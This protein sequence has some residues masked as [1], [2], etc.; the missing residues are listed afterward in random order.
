M[1]I[2]I[3]EDEPKITQHLEH[4]IHQ[5]PFPV[6]IQAKLTTV[7]AAIR[8]LEC[9]PAPDLILADVMLKDGI[10]LEIFDY[11]QLPT[12]VIYC[13]NYQNYALDA[14]NSHVIDYILKPIT[15][16]KLISSLE[17]FAKRTNY[18]GPSSS[19]PKQIDYITVSKSTK[20]LTIP[21]VSIRYIYLKEELVILQTLKNTYQLSQT[22]DE[23]EHLLNPITFYRANRQFI[24]HRQTI[25]SIEYLAARKI[26]IWLNPCIGSPVVVSKAKSSDFLRW[27]GFK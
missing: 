20:L 9:Q 15:A 14:F 6:Y 24:I 2:I 27:S 4:L 25:E 8:W 23:L 21:T 19:R 22:L 18:P 1:T 16:P 11:L 7:Q 17:K 26:G 10:S 12:P 3:L 13:T 5:L